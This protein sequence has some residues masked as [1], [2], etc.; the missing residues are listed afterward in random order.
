MVGSFRCPY[1]S[2]L[3]PPLKTV[4]DEG[5]NRVGIHGDFGK[6]CAV[7]ILDI[8]LGARTPLASKGVHE[9]FVENGD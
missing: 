4:V 8:S 9:L 3:V 6:R 1:F 7:D 5:L 2:L